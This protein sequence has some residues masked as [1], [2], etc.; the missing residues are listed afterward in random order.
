MNRQEIEFYLKFH[1]EFRKNFT[2]NS[3]LKSNLLLWSSL[4]QWF[5]CMTNLNLSYKALIFSTLIL[6]IVCGSIVEWYA[7]NYSENHQSGWQ[8]TG[9]IMMA[10]IVIPLSLLLSQISEYFKKNI[11]KR[12][13]LLVT[14]ILV[15]GIYLLL[16]SEALANW[17]MLESNHCLK[18][19]S[20]GRINLSASLNYF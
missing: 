13:Y 6:I 18:T 9:M 12:V 20:D 3:A 5:S 11:G 2:L 1:K 17:K 16:W 4:K 10:V 14:L 7:V 8:F 19:L 15:P